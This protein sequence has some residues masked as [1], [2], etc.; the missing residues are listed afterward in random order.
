MK[1]VPICVRIAA[2]CVALSATQRMAVAQPASASRQIEVGEAVDTANADVH[3]I[4]RL[5]RSYLE[6]PSYAAVGRGLWRGRTELE[7]RV[8]D[9]TLWLRMYGT[10]GPR[11][12]IVA[13][14][15]EGPGDS[16]YMVKVL[17]PYGDST[18]GSKSILA[19]QHLV[20]I[21][22]TNSPFGW[23]LTSPLPYI[24]RLWRHHRYGRITF[25][26]APGQRESPQ[27]AQRAA[28]FVDSLARAFRIAPPR[29]LDVYITGSADEMYRLQG[30]DYWWVESGSRTA[31]GSMLFVNE[32]LI[33]VG[34]AAEGEN[35]RRDLVR[36]VLRPRLEM[37]WMLVGE[38]MAALIGGLPGRTRQEMF[39]RL[40]QYQQMNP[41]ASAFTS[42][43]EHFPG[44]RQIQVDAMFATMALVVQGIHA[45]WG[46]DGLEQVARVGLDKE[47]FSKVVPEMLG[48]E[49]SAIDDWWRRAAAA[50][51]KRP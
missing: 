44:E 29:N 25:W 2:V 6:A 12:R 17:Y 13:V 11:L 47:L 9:L 32:R 51:A 28:D 20:A 1:T 33:V 22:N 45:R 3:A 23:R 21:R 8:G 15:G 38:G 19:L 30:L 16:V 24:T 39:A 48:I 5:T 43:F 36:I 7:R 35:H 50:A 40:V 27:R 10:S 4:V 26:Y 18:S 31:V 42:T 34:D 37:Q 46:A 41:Q 14:N 49:P